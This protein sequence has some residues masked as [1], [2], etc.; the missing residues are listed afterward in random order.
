MSKSSQDYTLDRRPI[1][2]VSC[3]GAGRYNLTTPEGPHTNLDKPSARNVVYGISNPKLIFLENKHG[4]VP[5]AFK[6]DL[7]EAGR[8]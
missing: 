8:A 1:V 7:R 5:G 6:H 3:C 4:H 2:Y